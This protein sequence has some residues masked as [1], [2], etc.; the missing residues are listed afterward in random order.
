MIKNNQVDISGI[1]LLLPP[2][3][4]LYPTPQGH[5]HSHLWTIWSWSWISLMC[6]EYMC[7]Q[8][9]CEGTVWTTFLFLVFQ[10]NSLLSWFIFSLDTKWPLYKCAHQTFC[11]T[12][13]L[14]GPQSGEFHEWWISVTWISNG[15]RRADG[16]TAV[17]SFNWW[18][19]SQWQRAGEEPRLCEDTHTPTHTHRRW[20]WLTPHVSVWKGDCI[21]RLDNVQKLSPCI[22]V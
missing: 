7:T 10:A 17:Q 15:T 20:M 19:E 13:G 14:S 22:S 9:G 11:T 21:K 1:Y 12:L 18:D 3:T 6:L 2:P 4:L 16:D 5:P 8:R